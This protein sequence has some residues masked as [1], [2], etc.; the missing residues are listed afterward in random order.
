MLDLGQIVDDDVRVAGIPCQEVLMVI[1]GRVEGP[2]GLDL[3]DDRR[4]EDACL[5]ELSDIALGDP[6]LLR[7]RREDRRSILGAD[8]G[9]LAIELGRIMGD[10]EINLQD[11]AVLIRRGS[12][13]TR[14]ASAWPVVPV[15]TIR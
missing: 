11:A 3:R 15:P 5:I 7:I 6:R 14:T 1:L 9:P 12:K 13:V 4:V 8:I 2:I 10:R